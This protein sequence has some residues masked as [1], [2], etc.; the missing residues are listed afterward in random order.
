LAT[1]LCAESLKLGD[2][3]KDQ[4]PNQFPF[5]RQKFEGNTTN[6]ADATV[7][8]KSVGRMYRVVQENLYTWQKNNKLVHK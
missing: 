8:N 7:K 1:S 6:T 4:E 2:H 3:E 5:L